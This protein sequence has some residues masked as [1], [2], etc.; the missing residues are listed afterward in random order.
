MADMRD[1]SL[2]LSNDPKHKELQHFLTSH[3]HEARIK[4]KADKAALS[5]ENDPDGLQRLLG[6]RLQDQN[7][8]K[9]FLDTNYAAEEL[10]NP[11]FIDARFSWRSEMDRYVR[12]LLQDTDLAFS[13]ELD[14]DQQHQMR[15]DHLDRTHA[16]LHQHAPKEAA[17]ESECPPYV[18]LDTHKAPPPGSLR[19][20][21][22]QSASASSLRTAGLQSVHPRSASTATLRF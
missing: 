14:D 6:G 9:V 4:S 11:V 5:C 18:M 3:K 19:W 15:C 13:A 12:R 7:G 22:A 20:A 17:K 2:H 8:Q 21:T 1:R 16:W 10:R